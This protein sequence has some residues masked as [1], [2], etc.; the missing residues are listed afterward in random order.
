M[1]EKKTY[2]LVFIKGHANKLKE[3]NER[4]Q[5]VCK[6]FG[7][8]ESDPKVSLGLACAGYFDCVL[9]VYSSK[10]KEIGNFVMNKLRRNLSQEIADTQ[11]FVC[12]EIA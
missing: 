11:T 10:M 7:G 12:W 9:L 2:A 5:K 3:L 6:D 4:I 1:E 8:E